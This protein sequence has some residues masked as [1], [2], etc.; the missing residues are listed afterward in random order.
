MK[1]SQQSTPH[2]PRR[3]FPS[4]KHW[5]AGVTLVGWLVPAVWL[6]AQPM[7][8][9]P[10][11]AQAQLQIRQPLAEV[12]EPT[13]A[14]ATFDP[15]VARPGETV[16][17]RVSVESTESAVHL[18]DRIPAPLPLMIRPVAQGQIIQLSNGRPRPLATFL[19]EATPTTPGQFAIP[20]FNLTVD[21]KPVPVQAATLTV[22][23]GATNAAPRRLTLEISNTNLFIGQPFELRVIL[24]ASPANQIEALREVQLKGDGIVTDRN[25]V[26]QSVA[27]IKYHDTLKPAFIYETVASPIAA[28]PLKISAQAF[29]AGREFTG[30]IS[31][32]G[33]VVIPGGAPQYDLLI[34][35][36]CEINVR[37]LPAQNERPGFTGSIG[38]FF[39]DPPK[40]STN[41]LRVGE[42]VQLKFAY[43]A[44]D[45]LSRLVPPAVPRSR[46][47]LI[48]ANQPPGS[49][50]TL[51]PLNDEVQATPV[52]PFSYFDP[53]TGKYMDLS[54]PALPVTVTGGSLPTEIQA[55]NAPGQT[56]PLKL[57]GLTQTPGQTVRSLKPLQLQ[58]WFVGLQLLP[59]LAFAGLWRW[60][61]HR[62]FL[63]AHPEIVRR[64]QAR[65]ALRRERKK[66]AA[67]TAAGDAAAFARL[68]VSALKIACAPHY[69][70][71]PQALVCGD[72]LAQLGE[73][74][75]NGRPGDTLRK[76]FAFADAQFGLAPATPENLPAL[77][78]EVSAILQ[79]LEEKL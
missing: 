2:V 56:A 4:V 32:T 19:F 17:Y 3:R 29:T 78:P 51:V 65:R 14:V 76:L 73:A 10:P 53:D 58:G 46:D 48:I 18:P 34:S 62:R 64:R 77:A 44:L 42:P 71:H 50:F 20:T 7:P 57:G 75:R 35:D 43:H 67:A 52:I 6:R 23:E 15:P 41:R 63:A 9:L 36:P 72:V 69:P 11:G 24:P 21:G 13:L 5:V 12:S 8:Q 26:R 37:P 55:L 61:K 31:I 27:T 59:V 33:Q 30:P 40:L 60:D 70:A 68:A 74:E 16:F 39:Y 49:G 25:S 38:K 79:Q 45:H 66:L 28:G 47:W 54:L 1:P 22:A